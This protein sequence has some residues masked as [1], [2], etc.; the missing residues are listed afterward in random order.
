MG[1][2]EAMY[3]R[4]NEKLQGPEAGLGAAGAAPPRRSVTLA[5]SLVPASLLYYL[6]LGLLLSKVRQ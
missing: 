1:T 4:L 5:H 2:V 6:S 3:K